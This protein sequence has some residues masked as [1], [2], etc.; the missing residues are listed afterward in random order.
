MLGYEE[1]SDQ[2]IFEESRLEIFGNVYLANT[3]NRLRQLDNPEEV[4]CKR[5]PWELV[6]N[7]KDSIASEKNRKSV[8]IEIIKENNTYTFKHD[9][10]PFNVKSLTALMYKYSSGKRNDSESTGRFGTGF[11]TTHALSKNVEIKGDIYIKGQL[12]GFS[13][14]MYREG[15]G[16]E[17]L[18]GLR[19]TEKSFK[20]Y[21]STF[22]WTSYK[23]IATTER[24]KEAGRLG[25]QNFKENISIVMLNC[26]EI[27]SIKLIDNGK[28]FS[29]E[30][31]RVLKYIY[32]E[33]KKLTLS[34]NNNGKKS[35]RTFAYININEYNK[36]L[37]V[38]FGVDRNLRICC[39]IELDENNNIY[40]DSSL[41]CLF[42][43]LPLVGSEDHEFPFIINSPD[44]EPDSERQ[45]LLLDGERIDEKTK[46]ISV[47]DINKMILD[48]SHEMYETLIQFICKN[49]IGNRYSLARGLQSIPNVNRYFDRKWYYDNFILPMR[50]ILL[51]YPIV[52]DGTEYNNLAD[53]YLPKYDKN[54]KDYKSQA[55][56]F[57]SQLY[58]PIPTYEDSLIIEK[59]IWE[60][61]NRLDY[62][63]IE[64]CVEMVEKL[65]NINN[66]DRRINV[67][68]WFWL[69]NFLDFI[70]D[71]HRKFLKDYA[72]IPNMNLK[73]I[74]H[75]RELATSIN[76]PE[77]MIDCIERLGITWRNNH[78]HKNIKYFTIGTD[79]DIDYVVSKIRVCLRNNPD[80]KLELMHYIPFDCGNDEFIYKR[81][82]MYEFCNTL[83]NDKMSSVKDGTQFPI[84]LWCDIDD[85]VFEELLSDIEEHGQLNNTITI[86]F[87]NKFLECVS[88]YYYNYSSYSIIPNKNGILCTRNSLYKDDNIPLLFKQC[89]NECFNYD[90]DDELIHDDIT[91]DINIGTKRIYDYS[92]LLKKYFRMS[93]TYDYY[94]RNNYVSLQ[95]KEMAAKYLIRI[96]P[97]ETSISDSQNKQRELYELY[98]IFTK[99]NYI[100]CEIKRHDKN[101]KI[102]KYSNKYIIKIIKKVIEKYS[103]ITDL[104]YYLGENSK[105]TINYLKDYNSFSSEGKVIPNQNGK[106][107]DLN[108]LY[109]DGSWDQDSQ[110]YVEI[111]EELKLVVKLFGNDI[112][113]I[114][115]HKNM[116]RICSKDKSYEEVC[117]NI[118]K[119]IIDKFN[120]SKNKNNPNL[121]NAAQYIIEEYFD[122]IG[123]EKA[124]TNFPK[125]H[126]KKDDI[127]L[128]VIYDKETRKNMTNFGKKYG[129]NS[130]STLLKNEN[131]NVVT[132]L[133]N[134]E[135]NDERYNNLEKLEKRY[136]EKDIQYILSQPE[137]IKRIINKN[138][139]NTSISISRTLSVSEKLEIR[140]T[141]TNNINE[142]IFSLP[143]SY[144]SSNNSSSSSFS[145]PVEKESE[146]VCVSFS[147]GIVS[148]QKTYFRNTLS[149]VMEYGDDF[150][151]D[152]PVN[153]RTGMCGEAYIYKLLKQS[154]KFKDVKWN[155][156]NENGIGQRLEYKGDVYHVVEDGSHYDIL[157]TTKDGRK[158][159]IEVKSTVGAFGSKVP[160]Y[161]S[162]KQ[163]EMMKKIEYPD[164]Y[165]LALV[166]NVMN[167]PVYFFMTLRNDII[168][169]RICY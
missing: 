6:Q 149:A 36:D 105:F 53:V 142:L 145:S 128:N 161:I 11:L 82:M 29:I 39:A 24:N 23:Y 102:W 140:G 70:K 7:A 147:N 112:K 153:K 58:N 49:N 144:D 5:W 63:N 65:G 89:M 136:S 124:M 28:E 30:R 166:F 66:L 40:V 78:I 31:G 34:I 57:I 26:P 168:D 16:Q 162:Q 88:K 41:P 17:L 55:Y 120:D 37:T 123:D 138:N 97:E 103:N 151:F 118:D 106:L 98:K 130:I 38:K 141:S 51:K 154:G 22:G 56:N 160:F 35:K 109:N 96:I 91:F 75:T 80:K 74:K 137:L 129:E 117:S 159:Y 110:K 90:I 8:N 119:L 95:Q 93:E 108:S 72:I 21:K 12:K 167:N 67:N 59:T 19:R 86:D 92:H 111:P 33:C 84:E 46:K 163:I 85:K 52:W 44:F 99:G 68:V 25:I 155:M 87:L 54:D 42:C 18:D 131:K 116:G 62:I 94:N 13:L 20:T 126:S 73:F 139:N 76:V 3:Q 32:S 1:D 77:N 148:E 27:N 14:T 9:G 156:L 107:C 113:D 114:L 48:R 169:K 15:E 133:I 135:L 125:T 122:I 164:E 81:A 100:T 158:I 134:G 146:K 157:C 152:N 104:S 79:H 60:N 10:A 2:N 150:D 83:W 143:S 64:Q 71:H 4:D 132:G 127:I 47:P 43:S 45:S 101:E 50:N 165:V 115:V 61:D 121:K 69:D